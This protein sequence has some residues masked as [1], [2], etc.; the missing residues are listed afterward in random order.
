M[1]LNKITK[2]YKID[3]QDKINQINKD[4]ARFAN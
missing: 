1:F 3:R 2:K 4:T